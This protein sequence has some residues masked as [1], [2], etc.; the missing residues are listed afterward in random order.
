MTL[1]RKQNLRRDSTG[2]AVLVV[3]AFL[4]HFL[5]YGSFDFEQ[6][7]YLLPNL[8]LALGV[9]AIDFLLLLF[10][11]RRVPSR[12]YMIDA[13]YNIGIANLLFII[14]IPTYRRFPTVYLLSIIFFLVLW[15]RREVSIEWLRKRVSPRENI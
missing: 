5:Y 2:F 6:S 1:L 7:S 8:W 14:L 13:V 10:L 11:L 12:V 9:S 15:I 3:S 4:L